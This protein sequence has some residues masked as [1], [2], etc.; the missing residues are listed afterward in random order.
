[1]SSEH[2]HNDSNES[3]KQS[4]STPTTEQTPTTEPPENKQAQV[5][6]KAICKGMQE[7]DRGK[8]RDAIKSFTVADQIWFGV[9]EQTA[10]KAAT[11]YVDALRLKDEIEKH[12]EL[13]GLGEWDQVERAFRRRANALGIDRGYAVLT[14][15]AWKAHK[16]EEDYWTPML[17][18]QQLVV[19]AAT[20]N[21][22]YPP[23]DSDAQHGFG[24]E[25]TRYLLGVELHHL[26]E[27]D[28]WAE[29]VENMT[30]YFERILELRNDD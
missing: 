19:Q 1:M 27:K 18:A 25:P 28:R 29:A 14:T 15:E 13:I 7:H 22:D 4:G 17:L 30:T 3:D 16:L 2:Q 10:R 11:A 23:K 5:A 24:P 20:G 26:H 9:D 6:A 21:E 8:Y 12:N